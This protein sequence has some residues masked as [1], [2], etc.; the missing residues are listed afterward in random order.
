MEFPENLL[1][2]VTSD[3]STN[4]SLCLTLHGLIGLGRKKQSKYCKTLLEIK[5]NEFFNMMTYLY[6]CYLP[7]ILYIKVVVEKSR[8]Y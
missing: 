7:T 5:R 4:K 3:F 8:S 1:T 6:R 2:I